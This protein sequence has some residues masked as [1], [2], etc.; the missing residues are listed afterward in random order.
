VDVERLSRLI[1]V[2]SCREC[3]TWDTLARVPLRRRCIAVLTST[4][5]HYAH[6]DDVV[7][8]PWML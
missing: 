7:F 4:I 3:G 8:L 5:A 2:K 6:P 1:W